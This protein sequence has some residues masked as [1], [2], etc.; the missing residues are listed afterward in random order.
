MSFGMMFDSS[1]PP[2]VTA[3]L[4]LGS[5][6]GNRRDHLD[7]ALQALQEHE[8]IE[9]MQVSSY[10]ETAPVGGPP[11]QADYLNAAA[12]IATDLEPAELLRTLLEI[13]RQLGRV[14]REHHG[15]RTIDLD[16]LLYDDRV[17]NEPDLTLP[18]PRMHERLFVLAPLA[19]IAPDVVHPVL[20]KTIRA[21]LGELAPEVLPAPPRDDTSEEEPPQEEIPSESEPPQEGITT[22]L[23]AWQ[24]PQAERTP[25]RELA[26]LRAVV[27]G[28]TSG[29][30]R[31]IALELAA[32]G[33]DVLIHGRR[34]TTAELVAS[35][36]QDQGV[37]SHVLLADLHDPRECHRLAVTAWR[38]WGPLDI[39]INNAGA[40]TL[41]GEAA[42]WSFLRKLR[43]LLQVDVVASMLL[44]REIGRRM[45]AQGRGVLI[46]MGWDQAETGMEGDSGQLFAATKGAILAF[47]KSLA[48]S[49]APEVRVN[50]L[51]PGWIRTAWGQSASPSWQD[52][53]LRET[54]LERWGTPEDVAAVARW[55]VSPAAAFVTGQVIRVNGGGVR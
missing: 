6:L 7:R 26:G 25:G 12:E 42:D 29:I 49:L 2:K 43:E 55:L 9:V 21:L 40:D 15:P 19:E 30:G 37:S 18:H 10:H 14:R 54:P 48:L 41:T 23:A 27:T 1:P 47:S 44:A 51:A 50:C 32:A 45:K 8:H 5:N 20:G 33:A 22:R 31:A 52:R 24:Q 28:S 4:A 38:E 11:G 16:L 13:E 46:N 34:G 3:Y 39:W 17:L 53:V 35:Q 36:V